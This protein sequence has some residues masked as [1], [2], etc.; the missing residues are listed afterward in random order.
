MRL[1][2]RPRRRPKT[3][4]QP[5]VAAI[6]ARAALIVALMRLEFLTVDQLAIVLGVDRSTA[7][8][9]LQSGSLQGKG[10]KVGKQWRVRPQAVRE[11]SAPNVLK[12]AS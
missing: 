6:E 11:L 1:S 10:F 5:T 9:E 2:P 4:R 8:R 7:R 12:K 3:R